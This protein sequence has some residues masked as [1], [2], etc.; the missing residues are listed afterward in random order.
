MQELIVVS[1][2]RFT[3]SSTCL[4]RLGASLQKLR[5]HWSKSFW[6]CPQAIRQA[7]LRRSS[8][9]SLSHRGCRSS[10]GRA[11]SC[12]HLRLLRALSA[13][14]RGSPRCPGSS[15]C[16]CAQHGQIATLLLPCSAALGVAVNYCWTTFL[17]PSLSK[18]P[19]WCPSLEY[20]STCQSY[21]PC[22]FSRTGMTILCVSLDHLA[23]VPADQYQ[24]WWIP[25]T[26]C[27]LP[28]LQ[29]LQQTRRLI[30][31][32]CA[33]QR[34]SVPLLSNLR[35][36]EESFLQIAIEPV[37]AATA[38]EVSL[39]PWFISMHANLSWFKLS[40]ATVAME[41]VS[42]QGASLCISSKAAW[43]STFYFQG[44]FLLFSC[45]TWLVWWIAG[46]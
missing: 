5:V 13:R 26:S 39:L 30:S 25:W 31:A 9:L 32:P 11:S 12:L 37:P 43:Q 33:Q 3:S 17:L 2:C 8:W 4:I 40:L 36:F 10:I 16:R 18:H 44:M 24:S 29:S 23:P 21:V 22:R 1:I 6:W 28:R 41:S 42:D 19:R 27:H 46:W 15:C 20:E 38:T 7:R 34:H 14:L 35:P 45:W